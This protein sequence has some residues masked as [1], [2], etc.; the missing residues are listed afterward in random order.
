MTDEGV[1][2]SIL[3]EFC[4]KFSDFMRY[5]LTLQHINLSGVGFS[6]PTLKYLTDYGFR[7]S[8]TL[9]AIHMDGNFKSV[10]MLDQFRLWMKVVKIERDLLV[11]DS[12]SFDGGNPTS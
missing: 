10:G 5:S 11:D 3:G 6:I 12:A 1:S 7:K 2:Q 9:L 4:K 8:K